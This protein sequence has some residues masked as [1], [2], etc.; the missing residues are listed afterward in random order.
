MRVNCLYCGESISD[1]ADRCP[2]CGAP[3][4]YQ[5]KGFRVGAKERFLLLFA[6]FS[7]VTLILALLLPR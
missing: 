5:K 7:A 4:H 1:E 6:L 2:H 3:S